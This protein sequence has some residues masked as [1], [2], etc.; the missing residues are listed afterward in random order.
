MHVK[1]A[2][3]VRVNVCVCGYVRGVC[4]CVCPWCVCVCV[5]GWVMLKL[6]YGRCLGL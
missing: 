5:R 2:R 6:A 4:V 3:N 1:N